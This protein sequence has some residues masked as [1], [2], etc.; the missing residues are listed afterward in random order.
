MCDQLSHSCLV[1]SMKIDFNSEMRF[2]NANVENR[3]VDW[4]GGEMKSR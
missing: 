1:A 4:T 2:G 3:T